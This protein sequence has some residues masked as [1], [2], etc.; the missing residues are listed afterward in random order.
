VIPDV[1]QRQVTL[2]RRLMRALLVTLLIV[3]LIVRYAVQQYF[4]KRWPGPP[5]NQRRIVTPQPGDRNAF[6]T[7]KTLKEAV[8]HARQPHSS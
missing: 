3:L 5:R 1:R 2:A 7:R 8:H 4:R 6:P